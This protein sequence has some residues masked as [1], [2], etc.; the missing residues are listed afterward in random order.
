MAEAAVEEMPPQKFYCHMCDIKF[1]TTSST[2]TCP[3]CSDGFVEQLESNGQNTD[4]DMSDSDEE[5]SNEPLIRMARIAGPARHTPQAFENLI[6]EFIFNLG[7]GVNA[8]MQLFLG[9]P[10]DYAWGREGLDAIVTQL[11]NQMDTSGPPPL[12]KDLIDAI[13]VVEVT[14]EQVDAKLQCSVCWQDFQLKERVRQLACQHVYHEPCIR[15]WLELHGTC[16]I[17]RQNLS[18]E[19]AN[20]SRNEQAGGNNTINTLQQLFQVVQSGYGSSTTDTNDST[21]TSS[22]NQDGASGSDA[23]N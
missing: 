6:H 2:Y 14:Q 19:E 1:E 3:Q 11:L 23:M 21:S 10:G 9:N 12:A 5:Y 7:V 22:N 18:G 4:N 16:P 17:C 13:P 20:N 15:P 8:N